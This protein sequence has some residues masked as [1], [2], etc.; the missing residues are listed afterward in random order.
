[1]EALRGLCESLAF[2]DVKTLVQSGNVVF[3]CKENDPA[4]LC[5]KIGG[6]IEGKFGFR[7]EIVVRTTAE[8]RSVVERN[9]FPERAKSE[10]NKLLVTF[11]A[12]QPDKD[13]Q[14]KMKQIKIGPEELRLSG[15]ELYIY[16][17]DGA[18]KSKL[19]LVQLERA[20]GTSGTARN[21]NTI[22]RLLAM[23]EALA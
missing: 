23:A 21:W 3:R 1:M 19:P 17:P 13:A 9:P 12:A 20:L 8:M 6:A 22:T 10:P 2:R 16:Y 14:T 18:G 7:P 11:L 5:K 15:S 4:R